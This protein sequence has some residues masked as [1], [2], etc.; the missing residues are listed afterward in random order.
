MKVRTSACA[1]LFLLGSYSREIRSVEASSTVAVEIEVRADSS[2]VLHA[3]VRVAEGM[4]ARDLME[5]LFQMEYVD[6]GKKFV[7]G[8]AGFKAP[9][10]EKKF[11]RLEV[12][13]TAAQVGIAEIVIKRA[14]RLRWVIMAY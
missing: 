3:Q 5:K 10:R 7:A 4:N 14:M 1:L 8:I 12:D 6:S 11:W 2:N 13:G 9:P